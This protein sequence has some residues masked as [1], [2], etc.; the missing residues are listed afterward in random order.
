[1]D[2]EDEGMVDRLFRFA[3]AITTCF[4]ILVALSF[5]PALLAGLQSG[6]PFPEERSSFFLRIIFLTL[7]SRPKVVLSG[8]LQS[9]TQDKRSFAIN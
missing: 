9:Q 1:M 8:H 6:P 3:L 2:R 4:T 7:S 5:V